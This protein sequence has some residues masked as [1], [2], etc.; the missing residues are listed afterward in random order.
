MLKGLLS[1]ASPFFLRVNESTRPAY[2]FCAGQNSC[3]GL[4]GDWSSAA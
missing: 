1:R 2:G 3:I 4:L